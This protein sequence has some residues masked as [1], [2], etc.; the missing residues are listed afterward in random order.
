MT[1]KL[2]QV[3]YTFSVDDPESGASYT[4]TLMEDIS[5]EGQYVSYGIFDDDGNEVEDEWI[6]L[7]IMTAVENLRE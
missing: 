4:V 6:A 3:D 1:A 7:S 2:I 5:L